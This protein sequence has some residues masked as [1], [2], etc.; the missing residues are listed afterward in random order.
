MEPIAPTL[1]ASSATTLQW[2][3][4]SSRL[5]G[6]LL[7]KSLCASEQSAS[8]PKFT[9]VPFEEENF[10]NG[11]L[12]ETNAPY[13]IAK[14]VVLVQLQSYRQQCGLNGI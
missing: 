12:E 14:K 10:W 1:G 6:S 11:Y 13:G 2:D 7:L 4:T 5:L 3:S 8:Y 9:P